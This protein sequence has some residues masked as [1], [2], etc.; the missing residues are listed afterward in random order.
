MLPLV[1]HLTLTLK[2]MS[3]IFIVSDFVT[4]DD[5]LESPELAHLAHKHDVV[6]VVPE[7]RAETELPAGGGYLHMRD[8]ESG[9]RVSVGLG[10]QARARYA[11]RHPRAARRARPRVLPGAHGPRVRAD[12]GQPG[13]AGAVALCQEKSVIRRVVPLVLAALASRLSAARGAGR[14]VPL[15]RCRCAPRSIARPSGSATASPTSSTSSAAGR[16]DPARRPREGE[17]AGQRARHRRQRRRRRRGCVGSDDYRLRYV[18]TTYR[19]DAPSL[20]IEPLSVALLR[21]ASR[22]AAAGR[23]AGRRGADSG[24]GGVPQHAAGPAGLRAARRPRADAAACLRG[25]RRLDR[26]R[27]RGGVARARGLRGGRAAAPPD[28]HDRP[29]LGTPDAHGPSH[30][31]RAAA[32][33][34]RDHGGRPAPRLRRDQR[35]RAPASCRSVGRAG[36]EPD[37]GGDRRGSGTVAAA[38]SHGSRWPRCSPPATTRATARRRR[39]RPPKPAATRLAAAEQVLAGR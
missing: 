24:R 33:A 16:R 13:A 31:A 37:G 4:D 12:H 28:A 30:H 22:T 15:R 23:R 11:A 5:V 29:P 1:R 32:R 27:A 20:S 39:C 6:A 38:G 35:R 18:L 10:R 21:A 26:A 2:R 17:A 19:V 7:D 9:R 34:R 8:L 36:A 25:A 3:L 14:A